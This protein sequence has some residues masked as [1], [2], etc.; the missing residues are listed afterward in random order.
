MC[1]TFFKDRVL[2]TAK[3]KGHLSRFRK[4]FKETGYSRNAGIIIKLPERP[5]AIINQNS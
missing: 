1:K 5:P 2:R 4:A 3:L